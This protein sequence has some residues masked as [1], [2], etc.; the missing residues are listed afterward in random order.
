MTPKKEK[1]KKV[2]ERN[3]IIE[4]ERK[5]DKAEQTKLIKKRDK[6]KQKNIK[7]KVTVLWTEN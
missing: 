4:K 2:S 3:K 5:E 6:A 7:V 1:M